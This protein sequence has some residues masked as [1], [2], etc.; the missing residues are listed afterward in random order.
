MKKVLTTR[1][2]A[3]GVLTLTVP[4]GADDANQPVRVTVERVEQ[5]AGP[6]TSTRTREEWLHF[7]EATAGQWQGDLERPPQGDYERRND[8]P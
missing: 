5:K 2:G 7:I 3:D 8:W 1:V 6:S 4:L